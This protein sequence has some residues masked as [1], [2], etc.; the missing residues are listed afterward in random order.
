MHTPLL[1]GHGLICL[2]LLGKITNPEGPEGA[3]LHCSP[4]FPDLAPQ[5]CFWS[6]ALYGSLQRNKTYL[7]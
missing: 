2:R 5:T 4:F 1:A 6:L 3:N 7:G